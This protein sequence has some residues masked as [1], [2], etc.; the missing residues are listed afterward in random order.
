MSIIR[1]YVEQENG[2]KLF[3][4]RTNTYAKTLGH[5]IYLYDIATSDFPNLL[6]QQC[7]V[8]YYGGQRYKRTYGLEFNLDAEVPL[9]YQKISELEL[10]L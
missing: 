9:H 1:E 6:Y 5:L 10:V 4:I 3:I 7:Y 2:K 8:Q